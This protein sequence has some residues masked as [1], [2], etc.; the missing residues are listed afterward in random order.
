[1]R[2]WLLKTRQDRWE[3]S[4]R[5]NGQLTSV[6]DCSRVRHGDGTR[7]DLLGGDLLRWSRWS[8]RALS[9]PTLES[10]T[11]VRRARSGA[12]GSRGTDWAWL[13]RKTSRPIRAEIRITLFSGFGV[14][15]LN[16]PPVCFYFQKEFFLLSIYFY[17]DFIYLPQGSQVFPSLVRQCH[18]SH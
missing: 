7:C 18:C 16:N 5:E 3:E 8:S 13:R 12:R 2:Y 9:S 15:L 11:G 10:N 17:F 14:F 1:M 4:A 6:S